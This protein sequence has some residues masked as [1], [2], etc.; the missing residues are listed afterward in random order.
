[1]A[2]VKKITDDGITGDKH[3]KN[4]NI[5]RVLFGIIFEAIHDGFGERPLITW[6]EVAKIRE[7]FEESWPHIESL[8]D[9]T[10]ARCLDTHWY[11]R[12][13]RRKD[14]ITRLVFARLAMSVPERTV[15]PGVTYPRVIVTGLQTM[16]AVML[17][18]REWR[19]LNDY[20]R[21]VFDY[22]GSDRDDIIATQLKLN[23]AVQLLCQRIFLPLLLRF[24]GFNSRRQELM[25]IINNSQAESSYRISD[26]EFCQIFETLFREYHD[27][28]ESEDGRLKLALYHSDDVPDV[29]KNIFESYFRFKSSVAM[30]RSSKAPAPTK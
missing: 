19:V 22:I 29:I 23:P 26:P 6:D 1:M 10:C 30:A 8:F 7:K 3:K 13:D 27:L 2:D 28:A 20:A 9:N 4:F 12:D 14:S 15:A 17:T 16:I 5:S 25:R 24:K 18:N 11:V 21:F